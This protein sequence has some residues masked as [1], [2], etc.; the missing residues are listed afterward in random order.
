MLHG[1]VDG[2]AGPVLADGAQRRVDDVGRGG[3][4]PLGGEGLVED[5][6]DRGD[7]HPS[8]RV[9]E[10]VDRRRGGSIDLRAG[11]DRDVDARLPGAIGELGDGI[12]AGADLV[13]RLPRPDPLDLHELA[14]R[15][16][17]VDR[18]VVIQAIAARGPRGI[19]D[20]VAPLPGPDRGDR[21]PAADGRLLDRV[22]GLST[23]ALLIHLT[24][25][26]QMPYGSAPEP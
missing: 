21:Q 14:H 15:Q 5:P 9:P 23:L 12:A 16:Q 19:D 20:G 24:I 17:P 26:V 3:L 2:P 11:C 10:G 13:C 22:H 4:E 8:R 25:P 18:R 1:D 6:F 7:V